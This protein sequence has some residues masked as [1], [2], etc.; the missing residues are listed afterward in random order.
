MPDIIS[1]SVNPDCYLDYRQ[2]EWSADEQKGLVRYNPVTKLVKVNVACGEIVSR[3][4]L[5]F[6]ERQ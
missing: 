4:T 1:Y 5:S 3:L 2:P 6:N